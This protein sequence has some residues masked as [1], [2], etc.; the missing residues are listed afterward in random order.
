MAF[1]VAPLYIAAILFWVWF[2]LW[3]VRAFKNNG[4]GHILLSIILIPVSVLVVLVIVL[5]L[6]DSFP[7]WVNGTIGLLAMVAMIVVCIAP[8]VIGASGEKLTGPL[9][10]RFQRLGSMHGMTANEIITKIGPP[11][12][13]SMMADGL[14][15]QWQ[16]TGYHIAI[17]FDNAGTFSRI[18]HEASV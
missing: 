14:L 12:A 6:P 17:A 16:S 11:N 4:Y 5:S 1:V 7:N 9:P 15:L 10:Q 13:R 8:I 3:I 2:A 18:E